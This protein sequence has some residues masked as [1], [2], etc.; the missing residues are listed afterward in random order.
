ME[1]IVPQM[2][3]LQDHIS[4]IKNNPQDNIMENLC[5]ALEETKCMFKQLHAAISDIIELIRQ[6]NLNYLK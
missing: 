5:A 2:L 4:T 6:D 3:S 1:V